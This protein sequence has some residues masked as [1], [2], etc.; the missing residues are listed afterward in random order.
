MTHLTRLTARGA[1]IAAILL[2]PAVLAG[3]AGATAHPTA[4]PVGAVTPHRATTACPHGGRHH[5]RVCVVVA[6]YP[7][8]LSRVTYSCPS[9]ATLT[10][11]TC[12]TLTRELATI[13]PGAATSVCPSG[14]TLVGVECDLT[15]TTAA[16][17]TTQYTCNPGATLTGQT[18]TTVAT[19]YAATATTQYTC[20]TGGVVFGST[21]QSSSPASYAA[22]PC[23]A[24]QSLN[25]TCAN[26]PQSGQFEEGLC[27]AGTTYVGPA[28]P[29]PATCQG[30]Y[31]ATATTQYTCNPGDTLSNQTCTSTATTSAATATT[32]YTCPTGQT[33]NQA[34]ET[35]VQVTT[36]PA[37]PNP[38]AYTCPSGDTL[39]G[40]YC[41]VPTVS[42]ARR[43]TSGALRL[44]CPRGGRLRG[45]VC[46]VRRIHRAA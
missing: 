38:S 18:C 39:A 42:A 37:T 4:S 41:L 29:G 34:Q 5:G 23:S 9:G 17:S 27:P 22:M 20:P 46:V 3:P 26:V 13:T 43:T 35:C 32:Q 36:Q 14:A 21:C 19:T 30:S 24:A 44:T 8:T 10:G 7:A 15:T 2:L 11:H 45:H 31:P 25:G 6:H 1:A 16:T 40:A 12:V 28:W 33:L